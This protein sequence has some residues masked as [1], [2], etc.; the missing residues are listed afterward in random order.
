MTDALSAYGA[1]LVR[2]L[3]SSLP[4]SFKHKRVGAFAVQLSSWAIDGAASYREDFAKAAFAAVLDGIEAERRESLL[5]AISRCCD[6]EPGD[7]D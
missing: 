7:S 1:V 5:E 4:E 2:V 3:E 6:C